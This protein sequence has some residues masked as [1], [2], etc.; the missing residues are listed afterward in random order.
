MNVEVDESVDNID[1]HMNID[2]RST[3]TVVPIHYVY[4][5]HSLSVVSLYSI[6]LLPTCHCQP[7]DRHYNS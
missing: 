7:C 5:I 1:I 4:D 2:L 6:L 3:A